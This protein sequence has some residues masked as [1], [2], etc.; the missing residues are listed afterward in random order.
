MRNL[1]GGTEIGEMNM[2]HRTELELENKPRK[3]KHIDR[4]THKHLLG[5]PNQTNDWQPKTKQKPGKHWPS[6]SSLQSAR[7]N[8]LQDLRHHGNPVTDS[9]TPFSAFGSTDPPFLFVFSLIVLNQRKLH[10]KA[11]GG[12]INSFTLG[13]ISLEEVPPTVHS[14]LVSTLCMCMCRR[15]PNLLITNWVSFQ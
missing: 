3:I 8:E 12:S 5:F 11:V 14:D 6:K 10:T 9:S 13:N 15:E 4:H 1:N 7:E 2:Q